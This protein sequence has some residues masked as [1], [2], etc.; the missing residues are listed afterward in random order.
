MGERPELEGV[1]DSSSSDQLH[2]GIM[3]KGKDEAG[4][5]S[6]SFTLII[7]FSTFL[8]IFQYYFDKN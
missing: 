7:I 5:L 4:F 2:T 6:P 8:L 1:G 3:D